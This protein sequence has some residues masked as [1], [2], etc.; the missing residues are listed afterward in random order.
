MNREKKNFHKSGVGKSFPKRLDNKYFK[1]QRSYGLCSNYYLYC[2][3]KITMGLSQPKRG[4]AA[5]VPGH[6]GG[7]FA[8][9]SPR[10]EGP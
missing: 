6:R 5:V 8:R 7:K 2:S 4:G 9:P 3:M 10:L 1:L